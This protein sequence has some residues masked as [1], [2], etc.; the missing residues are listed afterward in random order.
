MLVGKH[1]KE[2]EKERGLAGNC[3]LF[4]AL[5]RNITQKC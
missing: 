2:Q 5:I 1:E 3:G 4:L